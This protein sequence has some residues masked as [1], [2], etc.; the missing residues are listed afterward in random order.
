MIYDKLIC[1]PECPPDYTVYEE[2]KLCGEVCREDQIP[3]LSDKK[4]LDCSSLIANAS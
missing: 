2:E 3:R 1:V 4:C